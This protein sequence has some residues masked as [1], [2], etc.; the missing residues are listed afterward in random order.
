MFQKKIYLFYCFLLIP[1]MTFVLAVKYNYISNFSF[2]LFLIIYSLVYHPLISGI[3]L[4][5]SKKISKK[6]FW[7]NFIP[8][9]NNK[10]YWFLFF[11][12]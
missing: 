6:D 5:Q 3:R 2:I 11:N 9:W 12:K 8:F 1:F 7:K 10:Y 4:V